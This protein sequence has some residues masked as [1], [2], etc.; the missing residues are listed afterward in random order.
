MVDI[1][2]TVSMCMEELTSVLA[3]DLCELT[4][5]RLFIPH[6]ASTPP[7]PPRELDNQL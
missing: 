1:C 7:P 6:Y 4:Q 5:L 3:S 2:D